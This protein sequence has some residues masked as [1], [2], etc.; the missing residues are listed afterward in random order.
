MNNEDR[1]GCINFV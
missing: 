1:E